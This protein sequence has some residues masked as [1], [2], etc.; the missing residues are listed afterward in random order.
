MLRDVLLWKWKARTLLKAQEEKEDH[1]E[2]K[3]IK[4]RIS[5]NIYQI[6]A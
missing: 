3:I 1:S 4:E 6:Y 2:F 5:M